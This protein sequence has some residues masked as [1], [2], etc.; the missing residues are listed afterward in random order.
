MTEIEKGGEL[1]ALMSSVRPAR[2]PK[3]RFPSRKEGGEG[4]GV[5]I[6]RCGG[7]VEGR[8]D[9]E[10]LASSISELDPVQ[11]CEVL[12]YS[13]SKQGRERIKQVIR[14]HSLDRFVVAGCSP[15]VIEQVF[16][17]T[18]AEVSLNPFMVEVANIREQCSMVHRDCQGKA[19][20]LV[21]GAVA[22]CALLVPAPVRVSPLA[23]RKV[24]VVGDGLSALVA[25]S[26]VERQGYQ[27]V[28]LS[29]GGLSTRPLSH[30]GLPVDYT[31]SLLHGLEM[32]DRAEVIERARMRRFY[33]HPGDF[34][35]E[36][37]GR[38]IECGAVILALEAERLR[39]EFLDQRVVDQTSLEEMKGP[40]EL[41]GRIVMI[42]GA[43]DQG[44]CGRGCHVQMVENAA[45]IKERNPRT[46]VTVIA[47]DVVTMGMCELDYRRAQ[48]CGV[49][50]IRFQEE[51][52]ISFGEQVEV[53]VVDA[54]LGERLSLQ[55][56]LVVLDDRLGPGIV[57]TIAR[58]FQVPLD[59]SGFLQRTQ[60]K[61]KPTAS[62]RE[63]VFLCGSS[64]VP[65][66]DL[67]AIQEARAAASR[68]VSLVSAPTRTVGGE[69]AEVEAEKC[70]A[71]LTC[72]RSC[73][74]SA[75]Y[76]G[77]TGKAEIDI[78]TCQ[79]CGICVGICPSKAIQLYCFTDSQ[80]D[81]L[82]KVLSREVGE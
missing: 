57:D 45:H 32:S 38:T 3:P 7:A 81:A 23:S 66:T 40:S 33:G 37:E 43:E 75:P 63:G 47:R 52:E 76:I 6:C 12:D 35:L 60:V 2:P 30:Q 42:S 49:D 22:K 74:Y 29:P 24:L 77:E 25:A 73:P 80:I 4:M 36:L 67:E 34:S 54:N 50:F 68:A 26:E 72:I 62:I 8:V 15:K 65:G 71:C 9:V 21:R 61:L 44:I 20:T 48:E 28:L 53:S 46:R 82:S 17:T 14:D 64:V 69:V 11:A 5:F 10:A 78:D 27:V 13:C 16:R 18:A 39:R 58:M 70:S 31:E 51:P 19:E 56:D 55:A 41:P 59:E 79:G 1:I